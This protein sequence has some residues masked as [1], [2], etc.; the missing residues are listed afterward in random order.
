MNTDPSTLPA[1]DGIVRS[2]SN[3]CDNFHDMN[4]D[5]TSDDYAADIAAIEQGRWADVDLDHVA[6]AAWH[7]WYDDGQAGREVFDM[8]AEAATEDACQAVIDAM[9]AAAEAQRCP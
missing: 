6:D 2:M 4:D 1:F 8:T 3:L 5:A 9:L 7:C